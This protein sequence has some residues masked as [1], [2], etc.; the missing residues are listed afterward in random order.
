[1]SKIG[2]KYIQVPSGVSVELKDNEVVVKGPI[3]E[4]VSKIPN[5]L[6]IIKEAEGIQIQSRHERFGAMHGF[7]RS[8]LANAVQGVEKA[9]E[10]R[11]EIVGTGFNVKM[12]G[13]DIVLKVGF[14]H[15]V[16]VT[17]K[18]GIVFLVEGNTKIVVKGADKQYVGEV[19][20]EIKMIKKPDAY[21]GKGI[22]Y[23]GEIVR[24]KPGKKVK[25]AGAAA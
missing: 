16:V 9:W 13:Q 12:Q 2:N 25:A 23:E 7:F 20:R 17:K 19:A 22:R 18:E 11:L 6:K 8:I 24:I 21:K 4:I 3:G 5:G 14:S 15:P 1:M 10:K